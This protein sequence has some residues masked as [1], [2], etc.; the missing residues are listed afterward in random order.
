[1]RYLS[2]EWISEVARDIAS[3][4]VVAAAAT[5]HSLSVTQVVTDT[6]FGDVSYHLVCADSKPRFAKG[7]VPSDVTFSQSYET[8]VAIACGRLNAAES[9]ITGKVRFSGNHEKVI[10]AQDFFAALDA[11]FTRVRARTT[12]D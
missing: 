12:F 10:A 9:F 5:T 6:P 8:A 4:V 3:D 1:M 7:A 11:V 2:D